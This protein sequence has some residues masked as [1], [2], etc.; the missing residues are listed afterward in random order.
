VRRSVCHQ[1][2]TSWD[3][4]N[5]FAREFATAVGARVVEIDDGG[6]TGRGFHDHC[7][8]LNGP[9]LQSPKRHRES[10]PPGLRTRSVRN[11]TP[12]WCW[13][14][15]T[16]AGDD[17]ATVLALRESASNLSHAHDLPALRN[18]ATWVPGQD[19]HRDTIRAAV[20]SALLSGRA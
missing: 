6:I 16:R 7:R 20:G 12:L 8:R 1:D 9:V 13:S 15:V 17:R 18:Q 4:W 2:L 11:P 3:A 19:P 10:V 14:L 5:Q